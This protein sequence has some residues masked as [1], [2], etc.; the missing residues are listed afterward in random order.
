MNLQEAGDAV[1]FRHAGSS[2]PTGTKMTD[3]GI[4][5]LEEGPPASVLEELKRRGH[6]LKPQTVGGYGGYQAIARDHATGSWVGATEKRK[7]GCAQGY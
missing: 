4:V 7:D 3:G 1:R 6:V 5:H 2:E